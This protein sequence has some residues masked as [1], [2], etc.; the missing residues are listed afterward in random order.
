V[1]DL[2]AVLVVGAGLSVNNSV[3]V[4]QGCRKRVG[5]WERT[6]KT[7][8]GGARADFKP[9]GPGRILNGR[10]EVVLALYFGWLAGLAWS[11]GHAL[12]IPFLLS[13]FCG[14]G[15]VGARSLW[16]SVAAMRGGSIPIRRGARA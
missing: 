4:F 5:D 12:S 2:I 15:Y 1:R 10:T 14:L 7:G 3:A 8:D 13:L 11:G 16:E 6:S 9:Y